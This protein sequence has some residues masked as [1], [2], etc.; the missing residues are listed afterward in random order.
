MT[1]ITSGLAQPVGQEKEVTGEK[2]RCVAGFG[3][4]ASV[5]PKDHPAK[6]DSGAFHHSI[7]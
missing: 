1:Q 2:R 6:E 5:L 4:P 3:R 7:D